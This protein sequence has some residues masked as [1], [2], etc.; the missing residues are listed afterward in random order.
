MQNDDDEEEDLEEEKSHGKQTARC[1]VCEMTFTSTKQLNEHV[2]GIR[3]KE[4]VT[5]KFAEQYVPTNGKAMYCRVC[6]V[7]FCSVDDFFSY[8]SAIG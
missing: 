5:A 1:Y 4:T 6:R 3:H 2:A 7:T 8:F